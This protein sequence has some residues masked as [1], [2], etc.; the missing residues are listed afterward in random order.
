MK[1]ADAAEC[2]NIHVFWTLSSLV[3]DSYA[4]KRKQK[5][6]NKSQAASRS[7]S[8]LRMDV[9]FVVRGFQLAFGPGGMVGLVMKEAVDKGTA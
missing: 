8:T 3:L 1:S 6:F 2:F 4:F 7:W 5:Y 9:G